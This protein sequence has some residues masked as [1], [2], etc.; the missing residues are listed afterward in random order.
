MAITDKQINELEEFFKK[1][2]LPTTVE[3]E[4]GSTIVNV[5]QF[6]DSHLKV[7]R[8]NGDKPMY[9]VFF[10]RLLRLKEIL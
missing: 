1:V 5:R 10:N 4:E 3:L 8:N 2:K 6:I 7:L 9:E